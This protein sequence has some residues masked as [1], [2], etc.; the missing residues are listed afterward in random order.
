MSHKPSGVKS[1]SNCH[2]WLTVAQGSEIIRSCFAFHLP[3]KSELG[4]TSQPT[5]HLSQ[6]LYLPCPNINNFRTNMQRSV[7]DWRGT[8]KHRKFFF[9]WHSYLFTKS[10]ERRALCLLTMGPSLKVNSGYWLICVFLSRKSDIG[11][12]PAETSNL[13]IMTFK[14]KW[15]AAWPHLPPPLSST[16]KELWSCSWL[17]Q[18]ANKSSYATL[19]Q[20]H[21]SL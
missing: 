1:W 21:E 8:T 6:F 19:P 18:S 11:G 4:M 16:L 14:Y 2:H 5:F 13:E 9:Y 20:W 7:S 3:W 15:N 17:R 12:V 10:I